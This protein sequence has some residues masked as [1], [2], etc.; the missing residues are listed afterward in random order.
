M[1][2]ESLLSGKISIL[3][4]KI[5]I[6]DKETITCQKRQT[7]IDSKYILRKKIVTGSGISDIYLAINNETNE[8]IALKILKPT[9]NSMFCNHSHSLIREGEIQ[10]QVN[11]P[12]ILKVLDVKFTSSQIQYNSKGITAKPK[13]VT[14]IPIEYAE[15]GDLL[16][17]VQSVNYLPENVALYLFKQIISGVNAIHSYSICHRDIKLDNILLTNDYSI[18]I[19]DFEYAEYYKENANYVKL[20]NKV[21]TECYM[22]PELHYLHLDEK[23]YYGNRIDVFSCGIVLL[24]MITGKL[25]FETSS[26]SDYYYRMFIQD[27]KRFF[28]LLPNCSNE[29][30]QLIQKMICIDPNERVEINQIIADPIFN[31]IDEKKALVFLENRPIQPIINE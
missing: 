17:L 14:Y 9:Y 16:S 4:G 20:R 22:A 25:F 10:S 23:F 6:G 2:H 26:P 30:V 8:I 7:I 29:I 21:G 1:N 28:N 19:A 18:K 11:H 12:N 27:S 5:S 3:S 15:K 24:A 31:H 13:T